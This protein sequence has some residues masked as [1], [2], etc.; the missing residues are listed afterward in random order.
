MRLTTIAAATGQKSSSG[1][2]RGMN[3]PRFDRKNRSA[4]FSALRGKGS[5]VSMAMYQNI[6]CSISGMFLMVPI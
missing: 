4:R 2:G 1:S 3:S 5:G 6:S